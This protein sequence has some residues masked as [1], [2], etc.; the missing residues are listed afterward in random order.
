M[1]NIMVLYL[2]YLAISLHRLYIRASSAMP[3]I[4]SLAVTDGF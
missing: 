4:V 2:V 1:N 3:F